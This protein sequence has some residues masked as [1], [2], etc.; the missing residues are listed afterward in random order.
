MQVSAK[1]L[2]V[3]TLR[4]VATAIVQLNG[5]LLQRCA[6]GHARMNF[7]AADFCI[8]QRQAAAHV[9][10]LFFGFQHRAH[11]QKAQTGTGARRAFQLQRVVQVLAEHLQTAADAHQLAAVAQVPSMAVS[12]PLARR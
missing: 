1:N 4:A 12:Q 8:F 9:A 6:R 2:S 5:S 7:I 3:G 10:Q 11:R